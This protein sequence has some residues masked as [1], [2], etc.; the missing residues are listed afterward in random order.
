MTDDIFDG[1]FS[2]ADGDGPVSIEPRQV[3]SVFAV[4]E[5]HRLVF[6]E[7]SS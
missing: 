1:N 2:T 4:Q 3:F 7:R 5:N 6:S